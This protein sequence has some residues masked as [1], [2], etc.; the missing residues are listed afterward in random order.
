MYKKFQYSENFVISTNEYLRFI[1]EDLAAIHLRAITQVYVHFK[2]HNLYNIFTIVQ[3]T[4]ILSS[5][6][7]MSYIIYNL[8]NIQSCNEIVYYTERSSK[9]KTMDI[10]FGLNPFIGICCSVAGV[11][12]Q[13]YNTHNTI[14]CLYFVTLVTWLQPFYSMNHLVIH[15][16][17]ILLLI[18]VNF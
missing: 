10:W 12:G 3:N 4:H 14:L 9:Y 7:V 1:G 6:G 18:T 5:I 15:I 17:F 11:Y 16:I 8:K 13:T 2:L